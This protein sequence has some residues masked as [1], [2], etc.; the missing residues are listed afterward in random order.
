MIM[1]SED[2]ELKYLPYSYSKLCTYEECPKK[3]KYRYL[4]R[5][6]VP[7]VEVYAM[8]RGNHIHKA[9]ENLILLYNIDPTI[10]WLELR[11]R[12]LLSV[13]IELSKDFQHKAMELVQDLVKILS[14]EK[15]KE[16]IVNSEFIYPECKLQFKYKGKT[17]IN[18]YLDAFSQKSTQIILF[19][20][21]SGKTSD[22][23]ETQLAIYAIMLFETLQHVDEVTLIYYLVD[24]EI[25]LLFKFNRHDEKIKEVV[26]WIKETIEKAS[27]DVEFVRGR[28]EEGYQCKYCSFA[29]AC[30]NDMMNDIA[31]LLRKKND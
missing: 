3:F 13:K 28:T 18:G 22:Y 16:I 29:Q 20:W 4:D 7:F 24:Q 23:D 2:F 30:S 12:A 9:I 11:K 5:L 17:L 21:K 1:F 6:K 14:S 27:T 8:I 26:L 10:E 19:D 25:P 31:K 15:L